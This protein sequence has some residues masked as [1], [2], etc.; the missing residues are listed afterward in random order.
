LKN[1]SRRKKQL[2]DECKV[3]KGKEKQSQKET[4]FTPIP[5]ALEK[6]R[7]EHRHPCAISGELIWIPKSTVAN[8]HYNGFSKGGDGSAVL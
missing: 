5:E 2:N 8:V 1:R 4:S 3:N 7:E 6:K